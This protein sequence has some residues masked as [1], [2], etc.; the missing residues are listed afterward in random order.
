MKKGIAIVLTFALI[1]SGL[2]IGTTMKEDT[3][4][5]ASGIASSGF[6][7]A[8]GKNVRNNYGNGE[9]VYLRGTNVGSLSVQENWMCTFKWSNNVKDQSDIWRVLT[10]RFG[11]ENAR[12]L[13]RCYMECYFT[14]EDFDRCARMGLN[15][16][17][18]PLWYRDFV[19]ANGNWLNDC[20]NYVDW[21]V[22]EAGK[23]GIYVI[24]DMHGAYGSQ[25][26]SDH[27][28]VDGL[29]AKEATSQFFFGNN[30]ASNQEKYYQMWEKIAAHFNGNPAVAG[31]DLL[32]EP[33]CTYR[34]NSSVGENQLHSILWNVYDIA[35]DRIRAIDKDHMII[36]EATWDSWDL[37]NPSDYGWSNVMYEYHQYEY[38]HYSNEENVQISSLQN[39][40]N[41][42]FAMN[43]NVPSY[44]GEFNLFNS[45]GAWDT[46]LQ[47]L[48][49]NGL[50]WTTWTYKAKTSNDNWGLYKYEADQVDLEY[51]SYDTIYAKWS[52]VGSDYENT[53]ITNVLKK[54][55]PGTAQTVE[56]T[57]INNGNYYLSVTGNEGS[58]VVCADNEGNNPLV[59]NRD[60][61]GGAWETLQV[62]N[63]ADGTISFKSVINGKY[64]CAVIDENNQLLARS[65]AIN[66][67]EKF[68][69]VH[70]VGNQYGIYSC[71]NGKYVKADFGY[72]NNVGELRASSDSVAGSWEAFTFTGLSN[73]NPEPTTAEKA[74]TAEPTTAS[75]NLPSGFQSAAD[76]TWTQ[77][78]N[79]GCFFGNWNGKASG[80][81]KLNGDN[82]YEL[83]VKE[84]NTGVDWLVQAK[85]ET[86]VV[87]GRKYQVSV[88]VY[89]DKDASV[90]IK[91]DLSNESQEQ[92]YT[93]ISAGNTKTL[94]GT[95]VVNNNSI[96]I[97]FELGKGVVS[98]TKLKFSNVIIKEVVE[99]TSKKDET[100][101]K[102]EPTTK[103]EETTEEP[104]TIPET[105]TERK[106]AKV[107]IK[108]YQINTVSE[109]H[110]VLYTVEDPNKEVV[111]EGLIF[112]LEGY[113]PKDEMMLGSNARTVCS[114]PA[115]STGMVQNSSYNSATVQ[116]YEI[117]VKFIKARAY[118]NTG[119]MV[120]GYAKLKDG[121]VIYSD[122]FT[123]SIYNMA[124]E[125]YRNKLMSTVTEHNY[126]YEKILGRCKPEYEKINF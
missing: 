74:T 119:I 37:P 55:T 43:H 73:N 110:R 86:N 121:S 54:Y 96:R 33:F 45:D 28:G 94:T 123:K 3:V 92:V 118:Y 16:L 34:Y 6:L 100:T 5:A 68:K 79:W 51:D 104:A 69:L 78:G 62:I 112:G 82:S 64:V 4:E 120:R 91:E 32:N 29:D 12:K 42:I 111:E 63:N 53:Y 66:D 126:L 107:D 90:G 97:M 114:V 36:M 19:D 22:S 14:T 87:S 103:K 2:I 93:T 113:A 52:G 57:N 81:Y 83:Y 76:S 30:A 58:K 47:M 27:S 105:T 26:G 9:I 102:V 61:C 77:A 41:N 7:K 8:N 99:T 56:Y 60:S 25:N 50:H 71:A 40:I 108:G 38:S 101:K 44:L 80:G 95:Y 72:T 15:V 98:G 13:I 70:I 23:R 106:V 31:Y 1:L 35:Y 39:K 84:A 65:D 10:Q 75:N 117:T 24:I 21:F 48:R 89:A 124:D 122:V 59:A 18:L 125:L 46:G 85:Y 20:W 49:D 115:T 116:T 109:G 88:D 11:E 17:R 67:W